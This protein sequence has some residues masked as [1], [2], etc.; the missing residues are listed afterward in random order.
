M[1]IR[2]WV[3]QEQLVKKRGMT[4]LARPLGDPNLEIESLVEVVLQMGEA[5]KAGTAEQMFQSGARPETS[6]TRTT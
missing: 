4:D 3:N 5:Y 2:A 6:E 1:V